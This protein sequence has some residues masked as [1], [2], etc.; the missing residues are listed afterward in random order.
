[1]GAIFAAF[2]EHEIAC[3]D[4]NVTDFGCLGTPTE[5][6]I[7][8]SV[9]GNKSVRLQWDPVAGAAGY[10]V[11]RSDGGVR[12]C[13]QGKFLL[14]GTSDGTTTTNT[15]WEDTGLQNGREVSFVRIFVFV[16]VIVYKSF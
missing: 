5:Q 14:T 8:T 1:M 9:I 6:P 7:V 10:E 12:E 4:L 15:F 13:D 11:L 16:C 2:E 3:D